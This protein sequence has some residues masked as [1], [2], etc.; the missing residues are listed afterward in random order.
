MQASPRWHPSAHSEQARRLGGSRPMEDSHLL[1]DRRRADGDSIRVVPVG[2]VDAPLDWRLQHSVPW[3]AAG[4][5]ITM[6]RG[7]SLPLPRLL[8]PSRISVALRA[9]CLLGCLVRV[10]SIGDE[11]RLDRDVGR[12]T[13]RAQP[14]AGRHEF[15]DRHSHRPSLL[16][17]PGFSY[18]IGLCALKIRVLPL[19]S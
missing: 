5:A 15:A 8:N 14:V 17:P 1:A 9:Q 12:L 19:G 18:S 11:W 10:G 16:N 13:R 2:R 6:K 3:A 7:S 4:V